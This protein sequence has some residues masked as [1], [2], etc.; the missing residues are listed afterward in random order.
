MV[1][2][3]G[4]VSGVCGTLS[5]CGDFGRTGWC[6]ANLFSWKAKFVDFV[7]TSKSYISGSLLCASGTRI[8][9]RRFE[10]WSFEGLPQRVWSLAGLIGNTVSVWR[11]WQGC[12]WRQ[13]NLWRVKFVDSVKASKNHIAGSV[14]CSRDTDSNNTLGVW[15]LKLCH[16]VWM[17]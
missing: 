11:F 14:V 15:S 4:V 3:A 2:C 5:V 17:D 1:A 8:R 16:R 10:F 9:T 13:A 7:G 6:Q 12:G